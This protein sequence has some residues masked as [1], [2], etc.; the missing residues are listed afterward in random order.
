MSVEKILKEHPVKTQPALL[1]TL[2]DSP[3]SSAVENVLSESPLHLAVLHG[4]LAIVKLLLDSGIDTTVTNLYGETPLHVACR[5]GNTELVSLL[6]QA[7]S[8]IDSQ[9]CGDC[10]PLF[11]AIHS[12][13]TAVADIL[14]QAGCD[15][16]TLNEELMTPLD[17]SI[18]YNQSS[19]ISLLLK[20]GCAIDKST[21]LV[22]YPGHYSNSIMFSLWSN[23]DLDNV[24][25]LLDAGYH[26][27]YSKLNN[28]MQVAKQLD[29]DDSMLKTTGAILRE[30]VTLKGSCRISVRR[31]LIKIKMVKRQ[32]L[33]TMIKK[34]PIPK[35][36]KDYL[37]ML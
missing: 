37:S 1:Q 7:G 23:N 27:P 11:H 12:H 15:L 35:L 36:L 13:Q 33:H 21:G 9:D 16:D 14:I 3:G 2:V 26:L 24:R 25:V 30:P 5:T 22:Y 4:Q 29:W 32:S 20:G 10:T 34:L 28:L 6:I 8:N 31:H 19:I 18:F 17:Y